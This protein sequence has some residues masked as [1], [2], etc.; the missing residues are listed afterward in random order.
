MVDYQK[1]ESDHLR[2]VSSKQVALTGT[3]SK[4]KPECRRLG[5]ERTAMSLPLETQ[6][7]CAFCPSIAMWEVK[8][9]DEW[10]WDLEPEYMDACGE[11]LHSAFS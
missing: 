8:F 6:R 3:T 7:A 5:K 1:L 2:R 4:E 10:S 11:H 9:E